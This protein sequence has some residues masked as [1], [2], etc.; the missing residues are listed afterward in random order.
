VPDSVDSVSAW[1]FEAASRLRYIDPGT[2][3]PL[4]KDVTIT[5]HNM[6]N[7][8]QPPT[9]AQSRARIA[10]KGSLAAADTVKTADSI[11]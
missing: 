11:G 5:M 6:T 3:H 7:S 1:S 10:E 4:M 9:A 2:I 8:D